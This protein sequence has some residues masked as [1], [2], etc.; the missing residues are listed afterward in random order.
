MNVRWPQL[1]TADL[2]WYCARTQP[3]HE[4]IA[5]AN[6]KRKLGLEVFHP[7]LKMERAT[8]RGMVRIIEPL[9]PC[10]LF[11]RCQIEEQ[12]DDIRYVSGISSLVHF[13]QKIPTVP[14]LV[15]DELKQCFEAEEPMAVEE[16]LHPGA[17]VAVAEGA[18]MGS[19]GIV[20]RVLPAKDRVQILL[21]FLGRTTVAEVDRKSLTVEN[22]CMADLM[23]LLATSARA[24]VA[25]PV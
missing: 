13:G 6:L 20:V 19:H 4:H 8:R 24:G 9:F 14:D 2:A 23:P 10:Y 25:A 21:D 7:R 22:R 16:R 1:Q 3:K 11:V 12:L 17:E 5:A 18:F 15:I